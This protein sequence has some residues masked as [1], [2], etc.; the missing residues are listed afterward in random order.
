M[1]TAAIPDVDVTA[2]FPRRPRPGIIMGLRAGQLALGAIAGLVVV[3]LA[4]VVNVP[5]IVGGLLLGV[6]GVLLLLAIATVEDR[7]A[8]QLV[9]T[10]SSQAMRSGRGDTVISRTVR[11][12]SLRPP[13]LDH[14]AGVL[15]GRAASI[16]VVEVDSIAYLHHLSIGALTGIVQLTSPEFLLR[17][18]GDRNARVAGW[19][20]VL[21]AATRTGAVRQMQLV[22]RSVPDDGSAL[23]AYTDTHLSAEFR[24]AASAQTY[25]ELVGDLRGGADRHETFLAITV[26]RATSGRAV[27]SGV[28]G[29]VDTWRQE[30]ALLARLLPAAGLNVVQL[31]TSRRLGEVIRTG[32]DPN[33]A[34]HIPTGSGI[35]VSVAGPMAG[36]EEWDHLRTD[37]SFHAVLWVAE[38]P[39]SH[40]PAD[41]LWPLLFPPGVQRTLSLLYKPYTRAQSESAVRAKHSEIVQT[42]WLKNTLGRIE[43]LADSKEVDDVL[44]REEELL[45]GHGEVGLAGL[46]TVSAPTRDELE[47]AVTIVHAAATQASMDLRRVYGQQLQAFTVGAL[48]LGIPAAT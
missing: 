7:P 28:A 21:A 17:D 8:Y 37:G 31:M 26:A 11:V 43:T 30:Y 36:R 33:A 5:P 3:L 45:A 2:A 24:H 15:P 47:D 6:C 38:W 16:E 29:L 27:S 48:P 1:P 41:V 19:G 42:G 40:V 34:L 18:P 44:A 39:R 32:Y 46:V 10:R 23:A 20:R 4:F 14:G 9:V 25:R 22:E 13:R 35:E 12:G